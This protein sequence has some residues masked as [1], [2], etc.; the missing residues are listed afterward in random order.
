MPY[1]SKARR[2]FLDKQIESLTTLT[3]T[4]GELNYIFSRLAAR[5]VLDTGKGITYDCINAVMGVFSA[6]QAEF[7]RRVAV[8]YEQGKI[9][10]NGDVHEYEY[11]NGVS[12]AQN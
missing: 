3:T 6:A 7:Y 11:I 12:L 2:D 5:F 9:E 1:I 10:E 8:P 4:V